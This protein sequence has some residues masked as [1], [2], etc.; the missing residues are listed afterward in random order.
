MAHG[1]N[2]GPGLK[3]GDPLA[4][5]LRTSGPM[6]SFLVSALQRGQLILLAILFILF[7]PTQYS[8]VTG[9]L[10]AYEK[11]ASLVH[12]KNRCPIALEFRR[13]SQEIRVRKGDNGFPTH[14]NLSE[15]TQRFVVCVIHLLK[16]RMT[17]H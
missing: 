11:S 3:K 9:C 17:D 1:C 4:T 12:H 14:A 2:S 15:R 5:G 7:M 13:K 6:S 16:Y 10:K 8:C